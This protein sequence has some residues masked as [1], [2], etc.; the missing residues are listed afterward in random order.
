MKQLAVLGVFTVALGHALAQAPI[1]QCTDTLKFDTQT[2][3]QNLLATLSAFSTMSEKSYENSKKDIQTSAVT[4]YGMFDGSYSEAQQKAR[5]FQ[6]LIAINS[7]SSWSSKFV[8]NTLSPLGAKAYAD[9][10]QATTGAP[11]AA[12][13][14]NT[15][16]RTPIVLKIKLG[17]AWT[18]ANISVSGATPDRRPRRL[19]GGG[20]EDTLRFAV[21]PKKDFSATIAATNPQTRQTRTIT[22]EQAAYRVVKLKPINAT[23]TQWV[24]CAAGCQGNTSGCSSTTGT[25]FVAPV[26]WSYDENSLK[27]DYT[28]AR[29]VGG[30]GVKL[31]SNV[32]PLKNITKDSSGRIVRMIVTPVQCEGND[33]DTLG[34][35]TF[36]YSL[37]RN[38]FTVVEE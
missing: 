26:G 29:V 1:A 9:C 24:S 6:Q 38:G 16:T 25:T 28:Q 10:V 31:N 33:K 23:E 27:E 11:L 4:A 7:V 34:T 37:R 17:D 5:D 14:E 13:I 22:V 2:L 36:P 3:D 8:S 15:Q 18:R 19:S 32:F 30:P 12:W 20:S 21:D 35:S